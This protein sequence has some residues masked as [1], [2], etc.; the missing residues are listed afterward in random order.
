M[1]KEVLIIL[2][3]FG[4]LFFWF[5]IRPAITRNRCHA[6]VLHKKEELE[7]LTNYEAN[8][9]YRRCLA[10]WGLRPEDIVKTSK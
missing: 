5:Q 6:Y 9:Y 4:I 2:L 10:Q 3:I 7:K 8:N 1:K